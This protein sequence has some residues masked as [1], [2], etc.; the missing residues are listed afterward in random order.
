[1]DFSNIVKATTQNN[2]EIQNDNYK[3]LE[4]MNKEGISLRD[5]LNDIADLKRRMSEAESKKP[6]IDEDLFQVMEASV[7]DAESVKNA[8][9]RVSIEKN[10]VIADMCMKDEGFRKAY[11]DYK[12]AVNQ[13]YIEKKEGQELERE[14]NQ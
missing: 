6:Q 9:N 1:M 8:K 5:T 11:E 13:A 12:R 2:Y 3:L 7:K 14:P 4:Q 10:R